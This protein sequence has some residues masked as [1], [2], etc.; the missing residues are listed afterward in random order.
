MKSN[1]KNFIIYCVVIAALASV[2]IYKALAGSVP[3]PTPALPG[4]VTLGWSASASDTNAGDPYN[5]IVEWGVLSS[6][7]TSSQN[8]GTNITGMISGLSNGVTYYFVVVAED[9]NYGMVSPYSG[10]IAWTPP[11]QP[12]PAK[13][14]SLQ[15]NQ[16]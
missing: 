8:F 1:T 2:F 16:Q 9:T 7:Y 15:V 13:L 5:Y 11:I 6:N 3:V 4:V 12:L 14:N 10:Q